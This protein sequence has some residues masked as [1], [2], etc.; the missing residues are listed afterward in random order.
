MMGKRDSV[1]KKEKKLYLVFIFP[2]ANLY[3]SILPVN[4]HEKEDS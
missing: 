3:F 4:I 1:V 2:V